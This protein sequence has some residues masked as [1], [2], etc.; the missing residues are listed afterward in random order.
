VNAVARI[1]AVIVTA[2][3]AGLSFLVSFEALS[4]LAEQRHA[5]PDGMG[6]ALPLMVDGLAVAAGVA[7]LA[8]RLDGHPA[9]FPWLLVF[10]AALASLAGNVAHA[11]NDTTAQLI[12]SLP[13]IV[14]ALALH[15]AME[16]ARRRRGTA[17]STAPEDADA[18]PVLGPVPEPAG[19]TDAVP[20][21][22]DLSRAHPELTAPNRRPVPAS[23]LP[24]T[25]TTAART[26][27][28]PGPGIASGTGRATAWRYLAEHPDTTGPELAAAIGTGD[29]YARRL[30]REYRA[31]RPAGTG[32]ASNGT[33]PALTGTGEGGAP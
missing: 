24:A 2:A 15:L 6:W 16:E 22:A 13:A 7:A 31:T 17:T 19:D 12:A 20:L 26:A 10:G 28:P 18:A 9:V 29:S 21:R 25:S 11:P 1:V 4:D 23:P 27:P 5:L 14:A 30:L 3:L 8:R 32:T 33:A